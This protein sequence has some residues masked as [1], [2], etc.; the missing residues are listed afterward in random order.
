MPAQS[1]SV[2]ISY[3]RDDLYTALLVY[4]NLREHGYEVFL[5]M[6]NLDSGTYAPVLLNQI[7]ARAHFVLV[8]TPEALNRCSKPGDWVRREIEHAMDLKRNIVPLM[9]NGFNFRLAAEHLTGKLAHL[10]EYNGLEVPRS[11]QFFDFAMQLLREK[12]LTI[13]PTGSLKPTPAEEELAVRA[14]IEKADL[15]PRPDTKQLT[16]ED[17]HRRGV[18]NHQHGDYAAAIRYFTQALTM[19]PAFVQ[20][21]LSRAVS[22]D[23]SGDLAGAIADY[24]E[25]LKFAPAYLRAY[26][27]RAEARYQYGDFAGSLED[28][29]EVCRRKPD[30]DEFL[31]RR[32]V[33]RMA[34]AD[35][36]GALDDLTRA[37]HL[38]PNNPQY[39]LQRALAE[40][41]LGRIPEA[42]ED[43]VEA[44]RLKFD[45]ADAHFERGLI[46]LNRGKLLEAI[47][48]LT[49]VVRFAP[50]FAEAYYYRAVARERR[51]LRGT[52]G[53]REMIDDYQRYIDLG[54]KEFREEVERKLIALKR[55]L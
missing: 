48:D 2:F 32:G 4:K 17:F 11:S 35:Y 40:K 28:Y 42:I 39:Y 5:D 30:D 27:K 26:E 43:L 21:Y 50:T 16:A 6:E 15:Q 36:R 9:F 24:T 33:T 53:L 23:E 47:A 19:D 45:F 14:K 55:R 54:S 25:F 52:Q 10:P 8:L 38:D 37:I 41:A 12:Y 3:R 51:K 7:A 1:Q 34:L 13:I 22:R 46:L 20:V 18:M 49:A 29:N 31:A 44:L